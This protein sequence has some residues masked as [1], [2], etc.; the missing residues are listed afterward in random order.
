MQ[1]FPINSKSTEKCNF[2]KAKE[3]LNK[4]IEEKYENLALEETK[5]R[6]ISDKKKRYS[7]CKCDCG[8]TEWIETKK[9]TDGI[10]THCSKCYGE[11]RP[12]IKIK[13]DNGLTVTVKS[14]KKPNVTIEWETGHTEITANISLLKSKKKNFPRKFLKGFKHI[15]ENFKVNDITFYTCYYEPDNEWMIMSIPMMLEKIKEKR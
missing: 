3:K 2:C 8:N 13:M 1:F 5:I 7:R 10:I 6:N 14:I 12:N 15:K 11:I 9:I 4:N